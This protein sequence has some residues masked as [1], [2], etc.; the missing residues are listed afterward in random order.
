MSTTLLIVVGALLGGGLRYGTEIVFVTRTDHEVPRGTL[1]VNVVGSFVLGVV[2]IVA[3]DPWRA[4]LATGLCGALTTF[5]ALGLQLDRSLEA[6]AFR[7]AATYVLLTLV[8]G[9]GAAELGIRVGH[10]IT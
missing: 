1:L 5:S 10:W 3:A 6:R 4:G 9:L 2:V 8:L 7:A